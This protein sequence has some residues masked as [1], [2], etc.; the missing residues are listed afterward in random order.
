MCHVTALLS[1]ST[2]SR[3]RLRVLSGRRP[4]VAHAPTICTHA[5]PKLSAKLLRL[6]CLLGS[7]GCVAPP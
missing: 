6:A 7:H 2:H 3:S 5:D 1:R 4:G